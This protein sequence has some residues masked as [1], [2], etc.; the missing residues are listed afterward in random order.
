[1]LTRNDEEVDKIFK[2]GTI[3]ELKHEHCNPILTPEI[4]A[5]RTVLVFSVDD[6]I[7][8]NSE[9]RMK[10]EFLKENAWMHN[11]IENIYKLPN[12]NIVKILFEQASTAKTATEKGILGFQMRVPQHNIKVEEYIPSIICMRCYE[13]ETHFTNSSA[14]D[15]N[16]KVCSECS[17]TEHTWKD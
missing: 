10:E 4:S 15:K 14:K 1:M 6:H 8:Q 7:N 3:K 5:K 11:E 13:L 17:S 2:E 12:R 16:Y 9:E